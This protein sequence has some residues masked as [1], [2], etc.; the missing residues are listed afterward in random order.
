MQLSNKR[1][2]S[3]HMYKNVGESQN[4]DAKRKQTHIPK[5]EKSTCCK[6]SFT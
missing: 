6:I 3:M 5:K 1:K 2:Q 4:N